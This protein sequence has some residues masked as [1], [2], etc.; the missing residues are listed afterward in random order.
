MSYV[1]DN[2]HI[3]LIGTI[4]LN[5]YHWGNKLT[6]CMKNVSLEKWQSTPFIVVLVNHLS[7]RGEIKLVRQTSQLILSAE[8]SITN[9]SH[10]IKLVSIKAVTNT[11]KTQQCPACRARRSPIASIGPM[12]SQ[13]SWVQYHWKSSALASLTSPLKW[14]RT[15]ES[16]WTHESQ[17][18]ALQ[19][20]GTCP[21]SVMY[22]LPLEETSSVDRHCR[23]KEC[24]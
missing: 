13:G 19:P 7:E 20:C 6:F 5:N 11:K 2:Y 23:S 17:S 21:S 10:L 16:A 4:F 9:C 8:T 24:N 1:D 15:K 18:R 12:D 3:Q 22:W 14:T